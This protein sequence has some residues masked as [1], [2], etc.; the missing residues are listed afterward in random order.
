LVELKIKKKQQCDVRKA[1][2]KLA[3][4]ARQSNI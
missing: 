4:A 1:R 2:T 3:G